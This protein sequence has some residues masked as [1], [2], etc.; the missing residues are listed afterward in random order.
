MTDLMAGVAVTF[1]LIAAIFIVQAATRAE[2]AANESKKNQAKLQKIVSTDQ[3]AIAEIKALRE[4]LTENPALQGLVELVYDEERD[5]FLLTIVFDRG[6]LRFDAG[7]CA[8]T[9]ESKHVMTTSFGSI[10][11]Q[12]C[13]TAASGFIEAIMLE[14]HTD[15]IPFYPAER[16]CGVE[17]AQRSCLGRLATSEECAALGFANNVRLS[18]ARAQNVFFQMREILGGRPEIT[19]C[20][21][22]K[23]VV[24]GRGPVEPTDGRD[25]RLARTESENERNRRVVI[26]V[27]ATSR[28]RVR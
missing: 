22:A 2:A 1:L 13:K 4:V 9:D 3:R 17:R 12:V 23:F 8:I 20:L 15:N 24:A 27:R 11:E 5:P 25:W 16:V 28:T 19:R 14:G 18:A 10:F 7:D 6:R 21:D 26:K